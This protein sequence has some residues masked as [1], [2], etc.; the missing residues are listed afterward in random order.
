[1][2]CLPQAVPWF[3]LHQRLS[4][5]PAFFA[6]SLSLRQSKVNSSSR[7]SPQRHDWKLHSSH[8]HAC[9]KGK[10]SFQRLT[11]ESTFSHPSLLKNTQSHLIP[12]ERGTD[13]WKEGEKRSRI[14]EYTLNSDLLCTLGW[15]RSHMLLIHSIQVQ[16][17]PPSLLQLLPPGRALPF[18]S[19]R[20]P[21]DFL[22]TSDP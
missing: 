11:T 16:L 6:L 8:I 1:M 15:Q 17:P 4:S 3:F 12:G 9:Q 20:S 18:R 7:R 10:K 2:W 19:Q 13:G 21:P 14:K 5:H 22:F